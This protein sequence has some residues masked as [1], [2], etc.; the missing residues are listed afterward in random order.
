ML[1]STPL[2]VLFLGCGL[3]TRIHSRVLR[4][5]PGIELTYASRTPGR[6]EEHRARFGGVASWSSY[7][8]G[9]A[10]PHVQVVLIA[11]PTSTHVPLALMAL[12]ATK[13]VIV[14]KP[15]FPKVS[16][17]DLVRS[18]ATAARRRVFVAENYIYKPIARDLREIIA[19]GDIGDVRFVS[20]NATRRQEAKGWRADPA[21]SG[22]GAL[23][24]SGVHWISLAA[25]IGLDVEDAHGFRVGASAEA[26]R[27]SL[28]VL[29]YANGAMG[30]LA[31]SW[32][33]PAPF[34]GA[35][36]SKVQGTQGEVTFES[37]GF[38]SLTSGKKRRLRVYLRDTMGYEA[39]HADFQRA[40]RQDVNAFYTLDMAQDDLRWLEK[41]QT[42]LRSRPP[43]SQEQVH[44]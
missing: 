29:R 11:T 10:D 17:V 8:E 3:A 32:E 14:E 19:N 18:A 43:H 42:D 12:G 7:E 30:T 27:S 5:M 26:D 39:M 20:L 44:A 16:D 33:L 13:H 37:N 38:A 22:G 35:R 24:E 25:R 15:A 40:I 34:G 28:T 4:A 31:H 23:F 1:A 36:V 2:R 9:L 41:A 6:A 21:I